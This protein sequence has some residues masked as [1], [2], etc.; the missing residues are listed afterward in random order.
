MCQGFFDKKLR[1]SQKNDR[2]SSIL[3]AW[4][5]DMANKQLQV[6]TKRFFDACKINPRI[7][8]Y[9]NNA[10]SVMLSVGSGL[11]MAVL[12]HEL[13][14]LCP[15]DDVT[16]LRCPLSSNEIVYTFAWKKDSLVGVKELFRDT[17]I[18]PG[19]SVDSEDLKDH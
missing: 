19:S 6:P 1:F 8:N 10:I 14:S 3:P 18:E 11:G 2:A 15:R 12:P 9:Y 7:V 13:V 16:E 4:S 17:V 5:V